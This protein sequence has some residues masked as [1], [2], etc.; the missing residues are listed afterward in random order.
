L[1]AAS[2][3]FSPDGKQLAVGMAG[4]APSGVWDIANGAKLFELVGH[5]GSVTDIAFSPDGTRIAT[6][7][8]DRTAKVWDAT[9][10]TLLLTLTGHTGQ[11]H[12]LTFSPDGR[13]LT[14]VAEDHTLR[15]WALHLEDL[16]Q[17]A[18]SRLTRTLTLEEC[19]QYLHMDTCPASP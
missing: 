8:N 16:V 5:T 3:A 12:S 13:R 19:Q 2:V 11:V 9:T 6:A 10:G 15:V 4:G 14:T 7:S 18:R 1:Q 17:I